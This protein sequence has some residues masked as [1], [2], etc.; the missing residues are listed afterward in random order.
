VRQIL[1]AGDE[2]VTEILE[3]ALYERV[4]CSVKIIWGE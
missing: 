4:R 3:G 2:D 1:Q